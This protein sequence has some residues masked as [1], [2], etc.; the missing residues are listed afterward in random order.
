[1]EKDK[2][3]FGESGLTT[4]SANY[5]ANL[6]KESYTNLEMELSCLRLYDTRI[7]LLGSEDVT[8]LQ[9]GIST[10]SDMEEKLNTIAKLKSLIAWLR[11]AIKAKQRLITEAEE[12]SFKDYGIE[13][14]K[15]PEKESF[16]K[17]DDVI[18]SWGIKQRNRY[19]YLDTLCAVIGSQIHPNGTFSSARKNLNTVLNDPNEIKGTGRDTILYMKTPSVN[20]KEV[21]DTFM[22]LQ[23]VYRGYQAELNSMKHSIETAIQEDEQKKTLEYQHAYNAYLLKLTDL[24]NQLKVEKQKAIVHAQAL[25]IIIPDS[26]KS[27]YLKVS[28][29]GKKD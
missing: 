22:H 21:E 10:L 29:L 16:I 17:P 11:E 12:S 4:T 2:I 14:P 23:T 3:F 24:N 8:L 6:A 26:L 19:Y 7:K 25:K 13:V 27:V 9:S 18:A 15:A 1:M 28:S 20:P 5:I